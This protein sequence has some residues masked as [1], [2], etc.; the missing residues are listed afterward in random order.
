MFEE[1]ELLSAKCSQ[2]LDAEPRVLNLV[3]LVKEQL[4]FWPADLFFKHDVKHEFQHDAPLLQARGGLLRSGPGLQRHAG[5]V[6]GALLRDQQE[7]EILIKMWSKGGRILIWV[8]DRNTTSSGSAAGLE[9]F[10]EHGASESTG[11]TR[12]LIRQAIKTLGW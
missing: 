7:R 3:S 2:I 8:G 6:S 1:L 10:P 11:L 4:D 12:F 9:P 5:Y